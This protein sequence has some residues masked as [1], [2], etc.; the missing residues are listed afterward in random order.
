ML[1][2]LRGE[3]PG[4]GGDEDQRE[5]NPSKGKQYAHIPPFDASPIVILISLWVIEVSWN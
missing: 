4:S 3:V 1:Y 2:A 5:Q